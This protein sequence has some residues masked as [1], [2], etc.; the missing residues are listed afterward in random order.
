MPATFYDRETLQQLAA[1]PPVRNFLRGSG[2]VRAPG[3]NLFDSAK[4]QAG[5]E[6]QWDTIA[7]AADADRETYKQLLRGLVSTSGMPRGPQFEQAI[8]A[9]SQNIKQLAPYMMTMAPNLWDQVHGNRGSAAS[10]AAAI[11]Q[12]HPERTPLENSSLAQTV[13]R[14]MPNDSGMS[15]HD[16]GQVYKTMHQQGLLGH[17]GGLEASEAA[18]RVLH[19]GSGIRSL[20]DAGREYPATNPPHRVKDAGTLVV[21]IKKAAIPRIVKRLGGIGLGAAALGAGV[22]FLNRRNQA[23][24][25]KPVEP[26]PST[27]RLPWRVPPTDPTQRALFQ[28]SPGPEPLHA[29]IDARGRYQGIRQYNPA[30][31]LRYF[32]TTADVNPPPAWEMPPK[33]PQLLLKMQHPEFA[34]QA[35]EEFRRLYP[36]PSPSGQ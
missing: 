6:N 19:V 17:R 34:V 23:D 26:I 27:T 1:A 12:S 7:D 24:L 13:F 25:N 29:A 31:R 33:K 14:Q 9:G 8:E 4:L 35:R 3:L 16:V 20:V 18:N 32:Q 28:M 22:H 36:Q 5:R 2:L 11:S 15:A 21:R 30:E 10:L